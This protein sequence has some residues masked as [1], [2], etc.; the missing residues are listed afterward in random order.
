M[1]DTHC[2]LGKEDYDDI[3]MIVSHMGD[4]YMIASGV[5]DQTNEEVVAL[6]HQYP[7]IYGTIGIHPT[8]V[9]GCNSDSLKQI[10]SYMNDSKIV[11]IGEIGLD[12]H[13]GDEEKELQKYFFKEQIKLAKRY[14]KTIV[15]HCRDAILDT[16][17]LLKEME[18]GDLKVVFHCYSSSVEMARR[19]LEFNVMFGIGGV[20]TFKN[21][22]RLKEV[23]KEIPLERLLLETDS[24]YLTPVPFRGEK[25]EPK[26]IIYVAQEIAS[27]KKIAVE[28]VL[29]QTTLNACVQFDLQI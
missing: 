14:N 20:V 4:G 23:V 13:Y 24:P 26:N 12:Y 10:A 5:N 27:L 15:I 2:H 9:S 11:G 29:E 17:N 8:E 1:I 7:Q 6:C 3:S 28:K 25:N 21:S 16:Y 22:A 18:V 19:L